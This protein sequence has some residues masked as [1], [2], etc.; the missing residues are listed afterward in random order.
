LPGN[1]PDRLAEL[2]AE[3]WARRGTPSLPAARLGRCGHTTTEDYL[4]EKCRRCAGCCPCAAMR[5]GTWDTGEWT[6]DG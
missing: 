4:C 3:D 5:Q 6:G 1:Q 2:L